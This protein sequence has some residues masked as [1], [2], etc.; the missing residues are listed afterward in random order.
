MANSAKAQVH[1]L[2]Q[3][4]VHH[5]CAYLRDESLV[6]GKLPDTV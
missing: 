5:E 1:V 4:L 6:K 2:L 3:Y